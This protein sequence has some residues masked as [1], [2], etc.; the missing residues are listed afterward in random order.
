MKRSRLKKQ[1]RGPQVDDLSFLPPYSEQSK[2][3][4]LADKFLSTHGSRHNVVSIENSKQFKGTKKV[5]Q[6][7]QKNRAA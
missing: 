5:K 2:F 7:A 1:A 3:L 4:L 6:A